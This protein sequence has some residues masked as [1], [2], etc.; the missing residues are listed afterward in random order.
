[1]YHLLFCQVFDKLGS[2]NHYN[3]IDG[4]DFVD[5]QCDLLIKMDLYAIKG[6]IN[7]IVDIFG[8]SIVS[9]IGG[10]SDRQGPPLSVIV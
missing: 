10:W 4:E 9:L 1:M 2:Q 8:A 5:Y 7:E 6:R 3:Q